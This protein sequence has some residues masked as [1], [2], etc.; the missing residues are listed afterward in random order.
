[1][2]GSSHLAV[3]AVSSLPSSNICVPLFYTL[4]S[5]NNINLILMHKSQFISLRD[6]EEEEA[7]YCCSHKQYLSFIG[8]GLANYRTAFCSTTENCFWNCFKLDACDVSSQRLFVAVIEENSMI[9]NSH[10]SASPDTAMLTNL[11]IYKT[12]NIKQTDGQLTRTFVPL[13]IYSCRNI[14]TPQLYENSHRVALDMSWPQSFIS[15]WFH[16]LCHMNSVSNEDVFYRY[17]IL[18]SMTLQTCAFSN[19]TS[20]NVAHLG[21]S[22]LSADCRSGGSL[23]I[24]SHERSHFIPNT[25]RFLVKFS[26]LLPVVNIVRRCCCCLSHPCY[27][28]GCAVSISMALLVVR[29]LLH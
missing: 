25:S 26:R 12:V 15:E 8:D 6:V 2:I 11:N 24:S 22:F 16:H 29:C 19:A 27:L 1:M 28:L 3:L 21:D 4:V 10:Y 13:S 9:F 18:D 5:F 7:E 23:P 14:P 17:T 20:S